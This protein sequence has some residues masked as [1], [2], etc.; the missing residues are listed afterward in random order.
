MI[1]NEYDRWVIFGTGERMPLHREV[2]K[3]YFGIT[4]SY[5]IDNDN[6]K[7]DTFI[8]GVKI[9]NPQRVID[10]NCN[11]LIASY[12]I[13][14]MI[15]QLQS[16]G[17]VDDRIF[18]YPQLSYLYVQQFMSDISKIVHSPNNNQTIII[19]AFDGVGYGGIEIWSYDIAHSLM[20]HNRKVE[21][22]GSI[23]QDAV[24]ESNG[25]VTRFHFEREDF[26]KYWDVIHE[27]SLEMEKNTP[28][29]LINNWS[30]H[31]LMAA[32]I[33]KCK[34]PN[35]VKILTIEHMDAA[36]LHKRVKVFEENMDK[37]ICVSNKI[38]NDFEKRYN[39]D[40]K[41]LVTMTN[42]VNGFNKYNSSIWNNK[43]INI[44]WAGRIEK[45][46]KRIDLVMQLVERLQKKELE[47]EMHIAGDG[48][49]YDEIKQWKEAN[50]FNNV[51]L[52]GHLSR[53]EMKD[54]WGNKHIYINLSD[55]EG[56]CMA[57]LEAMAHGV[58]P[59]VTDV[60]GVR[61]VVVH[62]ENGFIV[63][64][65]NLDEMIEG[66]KMYSDNEQVRELHS[67]RCVEVVERKCNK[68]LYISN[69]EQL[70]DNIWSE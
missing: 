16:M 54:F 15:G 68:N 8:N 50:N 62:G 61:D 49:Y 60:S 44:C 1:N 53:E 37:I 9:C 39:I 27:M 52:Y 17:I 57:M 31:V 65:Q 55:Y 33:V 4:P 58:V 51:I 45:H 20:H 29:T 42:Y 38:K 12:Y 5:Y 63:H 19:D 22:Y 14:E 32:L 21:V 11:I 40:S 67:R 66:I 43:T 69:L 35:Q 47:Y 23:E 46:V 64:K 28:F 13:E 25:I 2:L 59:V 7:W 56:N 70:I 3:S 48:T 18:V 41:K 26:T 30:E 34:Y 6:S 10:D 24:E 36:F